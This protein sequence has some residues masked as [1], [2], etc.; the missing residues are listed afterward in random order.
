MIEGELRDNWLPEGGHQPISK[1]KVSVKVDLAQLS[2][3]FV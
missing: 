3:D 1:L 2:N